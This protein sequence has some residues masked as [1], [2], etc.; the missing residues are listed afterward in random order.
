MT[1]PEGTPPLAVK[2]EK[3][4]AS[5]LRFDWIMILLAFLSSLGGWLD[6]WA[7]QHIPQLETFFTPW[8]AV[9]YGSFLLE[10]AFLLGAVLYYHRKGYEWALAL[11][12]GY[13]LSLLGVV[14]FALSGVGD[15]IWHLLF[16]IERGVEALLSPTHLSLTLGDALIVTGPLRSAWYRSSREELR[17]WQLVPMLFSLS[18][19]IGDM[20]FMT[21]FVNPFI[22]LIAAYR[23]ATDLDLV[24]S[25]GVASMLLFTAML[26]GPTLFVLRRWQLPF[27]GLTLVFTYNTIAVCFMQDTYA[28]IPAMIVA[29][30]L[31]DTFLLFLKPTPGD[32]ERVRIFAFLAPA[33]I[34]LLYFLNLQIMIGVVWSVHLWMGSVVMAGLAGLLLS[35]LLLPLPISREQKVSEQ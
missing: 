2:T 12:R 32:P 6:S 4:V 3:R 22:L 5:T 24:Q 33:L 19:L 31:A 17:G 34:L 14:I 10:A 23:P 13:G 35:Y 29:G 11:P 20:L 8:H 30:L 7:H 9:L 21:Q 18:F 16:G 25:Y 1:S 26:I 15:L 28:L 27:G